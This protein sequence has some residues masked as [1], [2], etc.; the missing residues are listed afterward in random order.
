MRK[1]LLLLLCLCLLLG[2]AGGLA[3]GF[4]PGVYEGEG[5]GNNTAVPIKVA[6]TLSEDKIVSIEIISNEE[7]PAI[8]ASAFEKIPADI[9]KYQSLAVD[10]VSGATNTSNG[11]IEAVKAALTAA[12]IDP[13]SLMIEI[14]PEA[15]DL[16]DRTE[17]TDV[18]VIGAGGTGLAAALT[19]LQEGG[20]VIL[21][22][23]T[24]HVGGSTAVSGSVIAAQGTRY[25]LEAGIETDHDAWL[26]SWKE[27]SESEV[28]IIGEDP[29]Y[30]TYDRVLQYFDQVPAAVDWVESLGIVHWVSYPF[31]PGT[32][33]QVPDSIIDETGAAD[34]EGGYMLT[35]G[36]AAWY[37]ANGGDL[38]LSTKGTKLL[39]NE[40]GDVIG[41]TVEDANGAYDIYAD[42]GVVL[43][44]GGFAASEE[45]MREYLPQFADWIDLTT[46][47][48]GSTGDGMKMAVDVGGVMY[49]HPYVITL[50]STSRSTAAVQFTM[51]INLWYRLV[52]NSAGERFFNEGYMPYQ[53]TV[54]LSRV[55][56]GIAWAVGDSQYRDA[57]SL[58][59]NVDGVE[60]VTADTI[61]GLA[62]AMGVDA[63][64]LKA[65]IERYNAIP[66]KGVD[67]DFGKA[68]ANVTP[69]N[70]APYYAVRI[71]VC[72][73][74]TIGGVWTNLDY[75]VIREDGS[76]ING[77][78]AGGEVSNREMYAYAYS[79]GSGVGYALASGHAIGL[80]LMGK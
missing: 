51:S 13:E 59:A 69:I 70:T 12:G 45:M 25:A 34:P 6:V 52:V 44:T 19:V 47:G 49:D 14:K 74:G 68:V 21:V 31:F 10:A 23:K 36:M 76:V 17:H 35:D 11:I 56:D 61:E 71:Y 16:G 57:A 80:H 43:A 65:T 18:L 54:V 46:S 73:G 2:C 62:E 72:T 7:T 42:K 5:I 27:A 29:G 75:Q 55:E 78:Y 9:V 50:G 38:R 77:L 60:L 53:T 3:D 58:A 1:V 39:T 28:V 66:E 40:A 24:G 64:A 26:Q 30:P 22:E 32:T 20:K 33:Y 8:A 4:T 67:E 79:S 63:E 37:T 15:E 41:A 48:A